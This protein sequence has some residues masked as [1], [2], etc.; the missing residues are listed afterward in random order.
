MLGIASP[1]SSANPN[2]TDGVAQIV[3]KLLRASLE[4]L[5]A[6]PAGAAEFAFRAYSVL[7]R[8]QNAPSGGEIRGGLMRWQIRKVRAHVDENLCR[9][10]AIFELAALV[11]LGASYFQ[12][13]FKRSFGVS[14]HAY[15]LDRRIQRAQTLMLTTDDSLCDIA[16]AAGFSDQSHLT[17]RFHRAIG[18][19]P[20]V[21]RRECL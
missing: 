14:P 8:I 16:L 13:A 4:N 7:Q 6:D 10:I 20:N 3:S 9:P 18:M 21:W 19:T 17:T 15:M 1:E 11:R 5:D 2:S 12:R